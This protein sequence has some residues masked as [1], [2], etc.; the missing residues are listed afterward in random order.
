MC[1][2]F[3]LPF[4]IHCSF[5]LPPFSAQ[6]ADLWGLHLLAPVTSGFLVASV[7]RE[8]GLEM[9]DWGRVRLEILTLWL[10]M[11]W[12][13]HSPYGV[14]HSH[15]FCQVLVTAPYYF[16]FRPR[17]GKGH[18][19]LVAPRCFCTSTGFSAPCLHLCQYLF[20]SPQ[21]PCLSLLILALNG[22]TC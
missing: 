15:S 10:A 22:P 6:E 12:P 13:G 3:Y 18:L 14:A 19:R 17:G 9:G 16:F 11:D 4:R 2:I 21:S 7:P 5:S 1:R 20:N 8:Q